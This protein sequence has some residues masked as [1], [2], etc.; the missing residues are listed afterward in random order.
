MKYPHAIRSNQKVIIIPVFKK[1]QNIFKLTNI[2]YNWVK[3]LIKNK[4][5]I[6]LISL[7]IC[8][9]ETVKYCFFFIYRLNI[10]EIFNEENFQ[11]NL[12]IKP[13]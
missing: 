11:F 2:Y 12:F 8:Y 10:V 5:A 4:I 6:V 3:L 9:I 7:G 13:L 1:N